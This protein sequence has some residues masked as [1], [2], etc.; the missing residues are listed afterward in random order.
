MEKKKF[1]IS[2]SFK[3]ITITVGLLLLAVVPTAIQSYNFYANESTRREEINKEG[4]TKARAVELERIFKNFQDKIK[5]TASLVLKKSTETGDNKKFAKDALDLTFGRDDDLVSVEVLKRRRGQPELVDRIIN[6]EYLKK[7]NQQSNYIARLR[8]T[9]QFPYGNV[10][11][12]DTIIRNSTVKG[13]IPLMSFAFPLAKDANGLIEYIA[14]AEIRLDR[15]QALF[16]EVSES[17][18]YLIDKSGTVIAHPEESLALNRKSLMNS[19][20]VQMTLE[21]KQKRFQTRYENDIGDVFIAAFTKTEYGPVVISE[22]PESVILQP[23]EMIRRQSFFTAG[24]ILST[25]L[26][27][28]FLFSIT[29][30][31]P[32]ERLVDITDQISKG[33]FDVVARHSVKTSDEVGDLAQAFDN[34]TDGLKERDKVKN[35]FSKFQGSSIVDDLM[36]N[37]SGMELGGQNKQVTVFFSDIRGFTAFSESRTPEEVVEMLNEYFEVMVQI[38]TSN[39][40]VVDKFIGD[41]IMAVWGAPTP[42][43]TDQE[44]AVKACLE[45]RTALEKLNEKRKAKGQ[46]PIMIGMGLHSGRAISGTIGSEERMEYTVIGDTVNM[47]ARIEA[48][49]KAFGADLLVSETTAETSKDKFIMERAGAAEVKGKSE[50][51]PLYKVRGYIKDGKEIIVK[52]PYSDYE[53][54]KADKVKVAS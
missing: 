43:D 34:M 46:T 19:T 20:I 31:T 39:N 9:I 42:S 21:S 4:Q 52:T 6:E 7:F 13:A 1:R 47:A 48:S 17:T 50:P 53:A 37:E 32:I 5:V 14:L 28:V 11:A 3:L 30:T 49:T 15:I 26:F 10:F 41:A 25:A 44:N 12:G 22:V 38:I 40:G 36:S 2:I 35:L 51:L 27:L 23:A 18:T 29:L 16:S 33:N 8:N 45:M 54:E 24:L